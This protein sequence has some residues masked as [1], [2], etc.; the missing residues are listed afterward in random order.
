MIAD[1]T[2]GVTEDEILLGTTVGLT[3]IDRARKT[4]VTFENLFSHTAHVNGFPVVPADN[5]KIFVKF[6][7]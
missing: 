4:I 6:C 1:E 5:E 3:R 7:R 2:I